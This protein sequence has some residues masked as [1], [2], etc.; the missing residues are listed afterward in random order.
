VQ[1]KNLLEGFAGRWEGIRGCGCVE[2]QEFKRGGDVK[3]LKE[4]PIEG[5]CL[6][7]RVIKNFNRGGEKIVICNMMWDNLRKFIDSNVYS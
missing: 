7:L 2:G 3:L 1:V 5:R 6:S 4:R